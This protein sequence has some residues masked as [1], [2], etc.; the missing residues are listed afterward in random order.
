MSC[1]LSGIVEWFNDLFR[2]GTEF[3]QSVNDRGVPFLRGDG[4]RQIAWD[5]FRGEDVTW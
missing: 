5:V 4:D 2:V 1:F 3:R